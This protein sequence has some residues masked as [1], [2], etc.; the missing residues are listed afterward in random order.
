MLDVFKFVHITNDM[1]LH[2]QCWHFHI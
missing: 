2:S 1:Y